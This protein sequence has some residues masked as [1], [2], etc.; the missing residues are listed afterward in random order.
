MQTINNLDLTKHPCFNKEV[1]GQF[2]RVHLDV[3]GIFEDRPATLDWARL[4]AEGSAAP[5]FRF[6]YFQQLDGYLTL[7]QG[8]SPTRLVVSLESPGQAP[9]VQR[10]YDWEDLLDTTAEPAPAGDSSG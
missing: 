4:S 8:F 2:G 1:K 7:P 10:P 9:A 6:K 3:E 5:A